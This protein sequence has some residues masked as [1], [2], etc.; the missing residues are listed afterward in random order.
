MNKVLRIAT[1]MLTLVAWA[2]P[3]AWAEDE[4][5]F[6]TFKTNIFNE[7]GETNKFSI[8]LSSTKK[9]YFDIDLGFGR[10]EVE[11]E[12]AT[13]NPETGALEG[14]LIPCRVSK[15]GVV[16]IYGDPSLIDVVNFEGCYITELDMN[17]CT[18]LEIINLSHNELKALDLT[19]FKKAQAIYMSDNP[20]TAATPLKIGAPKPDLQILEVDIIG[21]FDQGFN[22]SDYPSLVTF[23]GYHNLDLYKIDPTGC[24]N[25]R[26][27]TLDMTNV[28]SVDVSKNPLLM[29]LNVSDSRVT[30]LDLSHNEGLQMLFAGHMSG[31]INTTYKFSSIDL[32]KN[33]Y[34]M[35]LNLNGNNLKQIDLTHNT[36]LTNLSLRYNLLTQI[37]LSKCPD[38]Y[39]VDLMQNYFDF[40]TLPAPESTWGEYFYEEYP[41]GVARSM[42]VGAQLDLASKVIRPGTTTTAEV[43]R[44]SYDKEPELL[45]PN[46]YTYSDGKISF[47]TAIA[48]SVYVSYSNSLLNEYALR[49]TPF[50]VK[51]ASQMGQPTCI[52]NFTIAQGETRPLNLKV[53]MLGASASSPKQFFIDL[54]DG[55]R[56][57]YTTTSN[58]VNIANENKLNLQVSP[59]A[60]VKIYIPE[61]DVLTGLSTSDI[62]LS[63]VDLTKATELR[64]LE[65]SGCSL[66]SISL[67]YNRCL[68]DLNLSHNRLTRLD[69]SGSFGNY[70]KNMLSRL[71]ASDN[72]LTECKIISTGAMR[73]LYLN[74]NKFTEF[75]LTNYDNIEVLNLSNN[76]I[77]G[78]LNIAYV[79]NATGI[80]L[81]SNHITSLKFDSFERLSSLLIYNN[82]FTLATLPYLPEQNDYVY[83]PQRELQ[84]RENA[85][86]VNLSDENRILV[87][88]KGT[89]FTWRSAADG[90]QL[91]Q[92]TDIDCKDGA[93]RFLRTDLGKVYCEMTNPAFPMF[94]GNNIFR[95]TDVN[96]VGAP[97][98]VVASFK[99]LNDANNGEVIFAGSRKTALYIDWRGDGTE[100][101][102]YDVNTSYIA[103][104]GQRTFAGANVKIY[105]YEQP[106]DIT[107]FSLYGMPMAEAD[108]TPLTGLKALVIGGAG[109]T[110]DNLKLPQAQLQE[111]SLQYNDLHDYPYM[112]KYP[113]LNMLNITGN[114]LTYFDA[115]PLKQLQS[116]YA[117]SNQLDS[118]H[119]NNASLW[120]LSLE[121]NR[122][123]SIDFSNARSIQQMNLENNL[124]HKIN[125]RNLRR[126]LRVLSISGNYFTFQT[127]PLQSDFPQLTNYFY[128]NQAPVDAIVSDDYM[129]YDLSSQATVNGIA[130]EYTWFLGDPVYNSD[131]GTLSGE[132]L[133]ADDEYTLKDGV[134]T[135]ADFCKEYQ[136]KLVCVMTNSLFPKMY[137]Q[138]PAYYAG[139]SGID[140]IFTDD[141]PQG[142]V[143]VYTLSGAIVK[144]NVELSDALQGL[145][146]GIYIV[147]G[148]KI[149]VQ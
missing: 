146:P 85:P 116:L 66:D 1:V 76:L 117:G 108:L 141:M 2:V 4:K 15:E 42:A 47:N 18:N 89:T 120:E 10:N 126:N 48:D 110:A 133:V 129:V 106:T 16:R 125:M 65:L 138:T 77:E 95:T 45:D 33:P 61:G 139:R 136:E 38:L 114:K 46:Y 128:A 36:H 62:A 51:T 135:F 130:T 52:A 90:H 64:Y 124:F 71:N 23:D 35:V 97:T 81:S 134:T 86:A 148:K 79:S 3:S 6:I 69:L 142:P 74:Q 131:E 53:G 87:D 20:F 123:D 49:T 12:P 122:L 56:K 40:N 41:I 25:L 21:H 58:I 19:P 32:S 73:Y 8:L 127:L 68:E 43:Y 7:Y 113:D 34:L 94:T 93:T 30:S 67:L 91:V 119:L 140:S 99:T 28:S 105:T 100:Y 118:I 44:L 9:E 96:V 54:G 115:S 104:P 145:R 31:S 144:E 121:H 17:A 37:D 72:K 103:Y 101:K 149:L 14:T 92:G 98:T 147:G 39:S 111:L 132:T 102:P 84:L 29:R 24:P 137:L 63:A 80:D 82:N 83:A 27:L 22:L 78:E 59:G 5:P 109:L 107:V 13:Y 112:E 55:N 75:D 60:N 88:G 11:I 57:S 50:V 26:V 70:E 143:N